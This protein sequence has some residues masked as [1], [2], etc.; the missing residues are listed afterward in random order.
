MFPKLSVLLLKRFSSLL[1]FLQAYRILLLR[2]EKLA[3]PGWG[4]VQQER[5][6]FVPGALL[7]RMSRS[8]APR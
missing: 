2:I 7:G 8:M 4:L 3:D 5:L 1:S 6:R